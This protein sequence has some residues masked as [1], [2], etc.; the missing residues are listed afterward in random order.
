MQ[1][2]QGTVSSIDAAVKE[3]TVIDIDT[4]MPRKLAYDFFVAATGLRR[5]WPSAPRS[6]RRKNYVFEAESQIAAM[7]A[8]A[9]HGGTVIVG[10]GAVGVEYAA[11]LK[12][13]MPKLPVTLVHSRDRLMSAEPLPDDFKD[14]TL[15]LVQEAGVDVRLNTRLRASRPLAPRKSAPGILP[16][17]N[18]VELEF[19]DGTRMLA[20]SVV[21]AVSKAHPSTSYLPSGALDNEK[22]AY[23]TASLSIEPSTG[24][25]HAEDHFVVGDAARWSGIKRCGTAMYMGMFAANNVFRRMLQAIED[26]TKSN[27]PGHGHGHTM[28]KVLELAEIPPMMGVAVGKKGISYWPGQGTDA[29]EHVMEQMFGDDLGFKSKLIFSFLSHR[30]FDIIP[31]SSTFRF[32]LTFFSRHNLDSLLEPHDAG[33]ISLDCIVYLLVQEMKELIYAVFLFMLLGQFVEE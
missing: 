32:L 21:M 28:P 2:I 4:K 27:A 14:R 1:Y 24:V 12:L 11:E 19:E 20:G 25:P 22:Y 3:A 10:G 17:S 30:S 6:L 26:K 15:E 18:G 29:G 9:G 7:A 23:V 5:E 33:K 8:T 13:Y 31:R 16:V